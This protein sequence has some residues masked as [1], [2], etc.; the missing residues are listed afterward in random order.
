MEVQAENKTVDAFSKAA[1]FLFTVLFL[2]FL[3]GCQDSSPDKYE[4]RSEAISL[5]N[6]GNYEQAIVSFN[7]ALDAS[8]G[9][10]SDFQY[11]L[12]KYR[13][14]CELRTGDYAAAE[15]TYNALLQ[16]DEAS[17]NQDRYNGLIAELDKLDELSDAHDL[18]ESGEYQAAYDK[19]AGFAHLDGTLSGK[20]AW[21][22]QAVCAEYLRDYQ[23]AYALF[24]RYI[25]EYPEDE[26]ALKETEFCRSRIVEEQTL[27]SAG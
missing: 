4:L 5:Y 7:E 26:S 16:L 19:F 25:L 17:E 23:D 15:S 13:A 8:K 6:A 27:E 18:F 3:S 9:E 12:L 24:S 10:V 2:M 14:E 11:D 22:N 1:K 21:F 20:T